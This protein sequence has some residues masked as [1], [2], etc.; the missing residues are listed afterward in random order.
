[1]LR[2]KQHLNHSLETRVYPCN[3]WPLLSGACKT[4]AARGFGFQLEF[5]A[6]CR[7]LVRAKKEERDG[8]GDTVQTLQARSVGCSQ[9]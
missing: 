4:T 7:L 8:E 1:V 6:P 9:G 3:D 5:S 2:S